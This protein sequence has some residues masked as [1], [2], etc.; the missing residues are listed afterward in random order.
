MSPPGEVSPLCPAGSLD[1]NG[2]FERNGTPEETLRDA[3]SFDAEGTPAKAFAAGLDM[4]A[5]PCRLALSWVII[6]RIS[7][8]VS[9]RPATP[10]C[11]GFRLI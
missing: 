8:R 4:R 10:S 7:A 5:T 3:G 6:P 11:P 2:F 9:V 1:D